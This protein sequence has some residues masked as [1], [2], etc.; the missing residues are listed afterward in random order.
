[1]YILNC[2]DYVLQPLVSKSMHPTFIP[3]PILV[4]SFSAKKS[5][6]AHLQVVN[7][8]AFLQPFGDIICIVRC[9][10]SAPGYL[11]WLVVGCA[12]AS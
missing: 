5:S 7:L 3:T 1:M 2:T 6:V 10:Q 9:V 8:L 4:Y 11:K 12:R